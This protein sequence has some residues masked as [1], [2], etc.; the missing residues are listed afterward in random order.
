MA[1]LEVNPLASVRKTTF[2]RICIID[3]QRISESLKSIRRFR[4]DDTPFLSLKYSTLPASSIDCQT[5]TSSYC[6]E[7][8]DIVAFTS[9]SF[10]SAPISKPNKVENDPSTENFHTD[11]GNNAFFYHPAVYHFL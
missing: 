11:H 2:F 4:S 9:F 7:I 1:S 5:D 3:I 10:C 8:P 6:L